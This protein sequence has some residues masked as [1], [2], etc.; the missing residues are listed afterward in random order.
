MLIFYSKKSYLADLYR[1]VSFFE[2]FRL[3]LR[4]KQISIEVF[5]M[6]KFTKDSIS[7]STV[8]DLRRAKADG[9]Y[10]VRVQ[11]CYNRIQ[12][13]YPTGKSLSQDEW[14]KLPTTKNRNLIS[15][16]ESIENSFDIISTTV[17]EL[18]SDADFSFDSLNSRLKKAAIDSIG[19]A[20][21]TKIIELRADDRIGSM[22]YYKGIL[23]T[24]EKFSLD[25]TRIDG[26]SVDWLKRY[27]KLMRADDKSQTTIG[28]Y[29]RGIR[30]VLNDARRAGIIRISQYPFGRGKY[31]IQA[32]EGR[33]MAL[34][35]EQVG[36]ISRYEDG[37]NATIKYRDYWMFLYFCNGLNVADFVQLKYRDIVDG[38]ICFIRQKTK[39][40]TK[41]QKEIKVVLTEPMQRIIDKWGNHYNP[42]SYI[43][44][45]LDGK[46]D[47]ERTK[48]KTKYLTRA[49]NKRMAAIAKELN[50]GHISTYTARHSF[51]TV[52]KRSGTNI[53]YISE[54]L[55]HKDLHTTEHYLAS[56]E[57][58]ERRK[59]AELLT[60]F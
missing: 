3:Y 18:A 49:I 32:G 44:P 1:N 34:T 41:T 38:E 13:Y 50:I 56:F 52:L 54:S 14:N 19:S 22:D 15:I 45:A 7:V 26:I 37:R 30:V 51:A 21:K 2:T 35:I 36:E 20:F 11:V 55:G 31:E 5:G 12:K 9:S 28:M 33:K 43:F 10:S 39:R 6:F 17:N 57:K 40:T 24:L 8:L 4:T 60:K 53:A 29:M 46:E 58:G 59:N 16:R 42:N 25:K 47:A 48:R 23:K 27:E